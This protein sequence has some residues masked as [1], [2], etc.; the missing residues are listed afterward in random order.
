MR[1]PLLW[2]KSPEAWFRQLVASEATFFNRALVGLDKEPIGPILN[3]LE[4]S[5]YE[6]LKE[7]LIRR[8]SLSK[9]IKLKQLQTEHTLGDRVP[10]PLL[11][12]MKQLTGDKLRP[13]LFHSLWF[14]RFL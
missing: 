6:I 8:L 14:Q 4:Q 12:E 7:H 10:S 1:V 13:A 3:L 2:G 11:R 5:S 9:T